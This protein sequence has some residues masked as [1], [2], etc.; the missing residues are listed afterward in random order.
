MKPQDSRKLRMGVALSR[1]RAASAKTANRPD[2]AVVNIPMS[3]RRGRSLDAAISR[4]AKEVQRYNQQRLMKPKQQ[5]RAEAAARKA[6]NEA[7]AAAKPKRTRS[8]ESLRMSRAKQIGKR[9][10]ISMNPAGWR[11]DAA[12]RMAA[13]AQRTQERALAT[14]G[15]KPR[16]R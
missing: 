10:S 9:R 15:V 1:T 2:N 4:A 5:V 7:S 14:Y 3:G 12:G 6:A 13:N 8:P 11:A 16:R